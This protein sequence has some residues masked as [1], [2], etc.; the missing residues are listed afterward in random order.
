[1]L[2]CSVALA[3]VHGQTLDET[4]LTVPTRAEKTGYRETSSYADVMEFLQR[5][6]ATSPLVHLTSFG[7]TSEGRSLP[8]AV[9]G[10]VADA[11]PAAVLASG[12][13]RL[14]VQ[15][16]I[17]AGEVCGKEAVQALIRDLANG[18]HR[19]WLDS[20]VLLIAPIY[21]ADGN[22]RVSLTNRRG[23]HG[24]VGGMGQRGNA[25]DLDLNRDHMK[26]DAPETR[27]L[28]SLIKSYDPHVLVDLHTT[29]GTEHAYHLTY[30]P[31]LNPITHPA[32][33]DLLRGILLPAVTAAVRRKHA[34]EFYYYGNLPWR[35]GTAE[36][37]WYT[38]DHRPRF[39]NNYVGLRNRIGILG[40]AYSYATF[41]ERVLAAYRL[42]EEVAEFAYR[43]A[44][45]IEAVVSLADVPPSVGERLPLRAAIERSADSVEILLGDTFVERNPYSGAA[46]RRRL[47]VR[48]P[49]RMPEF[50][51]FRPSLTE[52]MPAAYLVP[53]NLTRVL[54]LLSDHGI[55]WR[56]LDEDVRLA[57]ERF[58]TDSA[59]VAEREFQ[60]HREVT[61]HGHYEEVEQTL[62]AGT[63]LVRLDQP[64][65]RLA[66]YLLE[67]RS[68]D[69]VA[70]WNLLG[71]TPDS[72]AVYPILRTFRH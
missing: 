58:V 67:P 26:V 48:R 19:E 32:I 54:D 70:N 28:L 30:A 8:L 16:N 27:S 62:P 3:P 31:P 61:L 41:E 45:E 47:D 37:G 68:D 4:P 46:M 59:Q 21:N 15:A 22:E 13:T 39:S 29:N 55:Q 66:F 40:E 20:L 11:G 10:S 2:T 1:M 35:A 43:R 51:T 69:G 25:L 53:G 9:V 17:H 12:K 34:W 33:T 71:A 52:R 5:V 63:A 72:A 6:A 36:R 60:G 64:L 56:P 50:G 42:V 49:E 18:A 57:V 38:F 7:Y 23:Q 14:F 44:S 65:A 24:P